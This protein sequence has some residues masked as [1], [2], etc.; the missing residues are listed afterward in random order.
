M[1]M[2]TLKEHAKVQKKQQQPKDAQLQT[3]QRDSEAVCASKCY[4]GNSN[5]WKETINK[6]KNAARKRPTLAN[7]IP[8]VKQQSTHITVQLASS[9]SSYSL[10]YF[11]TQLQH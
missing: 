8:S 4:K 3:H 10:C 11:R 7:L 5:R 2:C 9:C 1:I 6:S